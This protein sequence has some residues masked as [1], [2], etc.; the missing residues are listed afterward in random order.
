M[1]TQAST[2]LSLVVPAGAAVGIASAY[3]MLRRWGFGSQAVARAVT[4]VS[5]WNQFANL[6]YPIVGCSS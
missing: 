1:M 2:A 4:L 5:L 6:A 3:G